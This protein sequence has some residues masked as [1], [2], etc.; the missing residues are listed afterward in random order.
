VHIDDPGDRAEYERIDRE[1]SKLRADILAHG[2]TRPPVVKIS[3]AD[4]EYISLRP[5]AVPRRRT[6]DSREVIA[7]PRPDFTA[8][9]AG[10]G[11][12]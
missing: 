9:D 2:V 12:P 6:G 3:T 5:F 4:G 11:L 10:R 7:R 8:S 1:Q